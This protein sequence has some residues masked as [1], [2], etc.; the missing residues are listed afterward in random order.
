MSEN[1]VDPS[2]AHAFVESGFNTVTKHGTVH[3]DDFDALRRFLEENARRAESLLSSLHGADVSCGKR[4]RLSNQEAFAI[5]ILSFL[6]L[7]EDAVCHNSG[8]ERSGLLD[9]IERMAEEKRRADSDGAWDA[10]EEEDEDRD[11]W[12]EEEAEDASEDV[13]DSESPEQVSSHAEHAILTLCER[14]TRAQSNFRLV[15]GAERDESESRVTRL[16]DELVAPSVQLCEH[17][18]ASFFVSMGDMPPGGSLRLIGGACPMCC[19]FL[20]C[21]D[22]HGEDGPDRACCHRFVY[23]HTCSPFVK[24][25]TGCKYAVCYDCLQQFVSSTT[26]HCDSTTRE[27]EFATSTFRLVSK[28]SSRN[29]L[30]YGVLFF[31]QHLLLDHELT[32]SDRSLI[33]MCLVAEETLKVLDTLSKHVGCADVAWKRILVKAWTGCDRSDRL[34]VLSMQGKFGERFLATH[35]LDLLRRVSLAWQDETFRLAAY[36]TWLAILPP[37]LQPTHSV[38]ASVAH[39]YNDALE[40]TRN[41]CTSNSLHPLVV[42]Q[43]S[44]CELMPYRVDVPLKGPLGAIRS[45]EDARLAVER[46]SFQVD[47]E[48]RSQLRL[49]KRIPALSNFVERALTSAIDSD[50]DPIPLKRIFDP[51]TVEVGYT[52]LSPSSDLNVDFTCGAVVVCAASSL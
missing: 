45:A 34:N 6:G 26:P 24:W 10:E 29:G 7:P 44:E 42:I 15:C 20:S 18:V 25:C 23:D 22:E 30:R 52:T 38:C 51:E 19:S 35:H 8:Y 36:G 17:D 47:D 21:G 39:D 48:G 43:Q 16:R 11:E 40:D 50:C 33:E 41:E 49:L 4:V 2:F 27:R 28:H 3:Q 12:E 1:V 37:T 14:R 13:C 9:R 46:C 31:L 5:Q 32:E